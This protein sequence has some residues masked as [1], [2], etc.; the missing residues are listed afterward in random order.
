M[1]KF[2]GEVKHNFWFMH[3]NF[4]NLKFEQ[5]IAN[6]DNTDYISFKECTFD[7]LISGGGDSTEH[8][9]LNP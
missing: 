7:K 6:I 2:L 9:H 5:V 8:K 3:C 4:E 1:H